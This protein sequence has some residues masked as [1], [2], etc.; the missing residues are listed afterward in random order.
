MKSKP[1]FI[2]KNSKGIEYRVFFKKP[3]G[4]SPDTK[5]AD[6]ICTDPDSCH[7][8]IDI[9]PDLTSQS[10][11]NTCIH[12]LAHAFFWKETERNVTKFSNACSRLLFNKMKWRKQD[13]KKRNKRAP[14]KRKKNR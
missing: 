9:R 7:P 14:K 13:D 5:G 11:L 3:D 1:V 4:R 8:E 6:G 12:E 2:F 10:E